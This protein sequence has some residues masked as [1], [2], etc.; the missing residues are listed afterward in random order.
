MKTIRIVIILIILFILYS[1]IKSLS[2]IDLSIIFR[3]CFNNKINIINKEKLDILNS[4]EKI[5]IMSNHINATDYL[6]IVFCIKD[7]LNNKKLFTVVTYTLLKNI[8]NIHIQNHLYNLINGIKYDRYFDLHTREDV[9]HPYHGHNVIRKILKEYDNNNITLL[10]P[11][12]KCSD[13][14]IHTELRPG[15]FKMCALNNIKIL[16]ITIMFKI[17][18]PENKSAKISRFFNNDVTV[19]VHDIIEGSDWQYL[20]AQTL[21]VISNPYLNKI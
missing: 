20:R 10:F 12:G 3:Y 14:G 15:C 13:T 19:I 9:N 18:N 2:N 6:I 21:S 5:I 1:Y 16:P 8:K 4:D 7:Y 17:I 11:G